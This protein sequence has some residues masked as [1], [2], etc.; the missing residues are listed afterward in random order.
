MAG[1]AT[2]V[3]FAAIDPMQLKYCVDFPEVNRTTAY[4]IGF[5]LFWLL[6]AASSLFT[7]LLLYPSVTPGGLNSSE[8]HTG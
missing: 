7:I 5:L 8:Q 6:T 3:F 4:S 2:M 1:L